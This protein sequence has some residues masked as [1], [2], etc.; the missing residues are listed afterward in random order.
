MSINVF[1]SAPDPSHDI[2]LTDGTLTYGFTF[3]G[4]PRVFQEIPLSPPA[5]SFEVQQRNW[6]GGRGTIN[7]KDDAT[8]F[9]DSQNMWTSSEG[10]A[11][12]SL[13]WKYSNLAGE[14]GSTTGTSHQWY[15]L[16][17]SLR[18]VA[19]SFVSTGTAVMDRVSFQ[20]RRVG[21]PGTL[22]VE[23]CSDN[24]T[25]GSPG[26]VLQTV[27]MVASTIPDLV[28]VYKAFDWTGTQA[29]T[30]A[31]TYWIKVYCAASDSTANHWELYC[32]SSS[33]HLASANGT[34][35]VSSSPGLSFR[36]SIAPYPRTWFRFTLGG[37]DYIVSKDDNHAASILLMNGFRG[38]ASAGA[39]TTLT[40][41][42]TCTR[43]YSG[44]YI[45]IIGGTGDGQIRQITS[46][47]TGASVVFTVPAWDVTPDTT[48]I[49]I[50]Y[51]TDFWDTCKGTSGLGYVT[52]QP[53]VASS[54]IVYFPQGLTVAGRRMRLNGNSHDFAAEATYKS[55]YLY[56]NTDEFTGTQIWGMNATNCKVH[57]AN[58]VTWGTDLV[59]ISETVIGTENYRITNAFNYDGDLI[60]FKEDGLYKFD[61]IR[62][63]KIGRNFENIPDSSNG[64]SADNDNAYLYGQRWRL[65]LPQNRQQQR[66][67]EHG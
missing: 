53:I 55:D 36:V 62:V 63:T 57:N 9:F 3:A 52:G 6:V 44:A 16:I 38:I 64:M 49:F 27:T 8:G 20:L 18:Y 40:C 60:F 59:P 30:D 7:I 25:P 65:V 19:K 15:S 41:A 34:S 43:D 54:H 35:W 21:T 13:R 26:T 42:Q 58:I 22:T 61:G 33:D 17:S 37:L 1:P 45:S 31:T 66:E 4:G 50:V 47:T 48:S 67:M 46:N 12:P 39:S 56:I 28:S 51:G 11:F 32:D 2:S 29:K 10:R 24:A 5:Q 23:L 14:E